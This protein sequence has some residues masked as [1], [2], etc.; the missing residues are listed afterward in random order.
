MTSLLPL[1]PQQRKSADRLNGSLKPTGK[2]KP[3]SRALK[4]GLSAALRAKLTLTIGWAA[5][6][7][8]LGSDRR[9][10]QNDPQ[11]PRINL[12]PD[13]VPA[14]FRIKCSRPRGFESTLSSSPPGPRL[15]SVMRTPFALPP[16][17]KGMEQLWSKLPSIKYIALIT[18][19]PHKRNGYARKLAARRP[20]FGVTNCSGERGKLKPHP[21]CRS[22]LRLAVFNRRHEQ[23]PSP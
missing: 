13:K 6:A 18:T 19:R 7:R 12:C 20:G 2:L 8:L 16:S 21:M 22:G 14:S 1:V 11:T 3:I 15:L 10:T 23:P 4:F 5:T 9:A 17:S